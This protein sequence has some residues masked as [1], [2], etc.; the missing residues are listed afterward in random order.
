MGFVA[1]FICFA[2]LQK[3]WKLVKIWQSY[4]VF[5]GGNFFWDTVY[6][7]FIVILYT[8]RQWKVESVEIRTIKQL[9]GVAINKELSCI[10]L[11]KMLRKLQNILINWN[12][13]NRF[14]WYGHRLRKN[15]NDYKI[16]NW[17]AIKPKATQRH[18]LKSL[19]L[20]LVLL[21][22]FYIHIMLIGGNLP[23]G[24]LEF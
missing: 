20:T 7:V 4:G 14:K 12:Q 2:A 10:E 9:C 16:M 17:K 3:F 21:I 23:P 19:L 22:C 18:D 5:K 8:A 15:E 24:Y 11:R 13:W 6:L 1:N